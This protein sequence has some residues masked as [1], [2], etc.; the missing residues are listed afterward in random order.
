MSSI[1]TVGPDGA[2]AAVYDDELAEVLRDLGSFEVRRASHVEFDGVLQGWMIEMTEYGGF[3]AGPFRTRQAAVLWE[4]AYLETRLAGG[5]D[6]EAGVAAARAA[7][8][9][10]GKNG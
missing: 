9:V 4:V 7:Q 10:E 6:A 1:V 8:A 3:V 5:G 2:V